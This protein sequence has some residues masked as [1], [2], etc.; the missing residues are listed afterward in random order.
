MCAHREGAGSRFEGSPQE[1]NPG[2]SHSIDACASIDGSPVCMHLFMDARWVYRIYL[3]MLGGCTSPAKK[4][5]RALPKLVLLEPLG[6]LNFGEALPVVKM[7]QGLGFR[8]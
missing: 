2:I 8:V 7:V 3:W 6:A 1:T 4:P 5:S